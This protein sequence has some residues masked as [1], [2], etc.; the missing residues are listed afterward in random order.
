MMQDKFTNISS[1]DKHDFSSILIHCHTKPLFQNRP[2]KYAIT[3][4][5]DEKREMLF[6]TPYIA[7][8]SHFQ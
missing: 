7:L 5:L 4:V 6:S 8:I 1:K 3:K 2:L